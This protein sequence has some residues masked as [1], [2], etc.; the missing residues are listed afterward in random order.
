MSLAHPLCIVRHGETDW[1]VEGR[2][3]GQRDIDLNGRG[4]DQA[5]AVGQILKSDHPEI[6]TFD[7]VSSPLARAQDTMRLMRG[8]MG[9]DPDA[10]RLDDRLKELTFGAWEGFTWRE[11]VERDPQGSAARE[12]D[13]WAY[14]PPGGESYEMLSTRIAVWLA[15]LKGPTLAV[16]HG[17]VARVLLGLI[18]GVSQKEL[19]LRD[20][21]QGRALLF[22]GADARWV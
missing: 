8:A 20:I 17:G 18:V 10:F 4:R 7:F 11:M 15:D 13:K 21:K 19:P 3:Q 9:L 14:C 1:N 16:T 2:L 22:S 12:A 5:A 6:L